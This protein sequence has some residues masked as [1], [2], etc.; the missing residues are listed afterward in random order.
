MVLVVI[1]FVE[2]LVIFLR[3]VLYSTTAFVKHYTRIFSSNKEG[4]NCYIVVHF[5]T[6]WA[7]IVHL[8]SN[9]I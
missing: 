8:H 9:I 3:I 7:K 4:F 1:H 2:F 6:E 5:A